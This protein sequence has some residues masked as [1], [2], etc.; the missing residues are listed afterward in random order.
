MKFYD[1]LQQPTGGMLQPT[2]I[3]NCGIT[4]QL[5]FM[6]NFQSNPQPCSHAYS[7]T[8]CHGIETQLYKFIN[9]CKKV[10]NSRE[11]IEQQNGE[12]GMDL[13]IKWVL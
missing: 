8:V 9:I 10:P 11:Q 6:S 12:E 13:T 4:R 3:D 1:L 7:A 5:I 2:H